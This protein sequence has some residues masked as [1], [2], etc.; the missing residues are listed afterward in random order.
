MN[1]KIK[2]VLIILAIILILLLLFLSLFTREVKAYKAIKNDAIKGITVTGTVKASDDVE[3]TTRIT[4]RLDK[5]LVSDGDYVKKGDLIAILKRDENL[6]DLKSAKGRLYTAQ[7]ELNNLLTEPREQNVSIARAREREVIQR[8]QG[9]H[10]RLKRNKV[11]LKDA[12]REEKRFKALYEAGAV[13]EREYLQVK[14]VRDE[15]IQTIGETEEEIDIQHEQLKI[16]KQ[17]LSLALNNIKPEQIEAAQGRVVSAKGELDSSLAELNNYLIRAPKD[18]YIAD[19][20]LDPGEI[21]S[22]SN[23]VVRLIVEESIY[24]GADVE[25]NSINLLKKGQKALVIFDAYPEKVFES[26]IYFLDKLVNPETGT[27]EAKIKTP[28]K[29]SY[30][31]LT[32]MTFD[33][34]IIINSFKNVII[35]P[36]DFVFKEEGNFFVFKK[37]GFWAKKTIIKAKEFDNGRIRVL[38][39]IEQGDV[40]LK[41]LDSQKLKNHQLIKIR[42]YIE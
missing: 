32:G 30:K 18:G 35:L 20:F 28:Y 34:T 2:I 37:V 31:L 11:D 12:Q 29:F 33:A 40:V 41:G 42:K 8:L 3:V 22:P 27:F 14:L 16:A 15:L 10:F 6:G 24:L 4:A 23:P 21:V 9:L 17:D 39:G 5:L 38:S 13:S 25:E 1:N 26:N 7:S 36:S 19:S